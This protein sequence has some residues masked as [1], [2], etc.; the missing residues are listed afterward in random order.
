LAQDTQC[1]V[2]PNLTHNAIQQGTVDIVLDELK[3]P[4]AIA[5]IMT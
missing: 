5:S 1:C 2:Y 3:L 4:Q